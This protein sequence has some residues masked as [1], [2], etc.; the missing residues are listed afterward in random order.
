[1]RQ[2]QTPLGGDMTAMEALAEQVEA[3]GGFMK[4]GMRDIR[5]AHGT[6]KLGSG[7]VREIHAKMA[8]A[9]LGHVGHRGP[10]LPTSQAEFVWVYSLNGPV[11]D[12]IKAVKESDDAEK[13]ILQIRELVAV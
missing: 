11:A 10:D 13:T 2:A 9:G 7:V 12:L 1:M 5:T 4:I 6:Q 8:A 3:A